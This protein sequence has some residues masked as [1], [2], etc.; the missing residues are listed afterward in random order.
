MDTE[1][2]PNY[3]SLF[4][5]ASI[6]T[7]VFSRLLK[8]F[9]T[10]A[11]ICALPEAEFVKMG[12]EAA[13]IEDLKAGA[14]DKKVRQ[15][16]DQDLSWSTGKENAIISYESRFYPPLLKEIQ[17]SP[18]LLYVVGKKSKLTEPQ[19]AIVGSRKSSNYGRRNAYWMANELS[20]AG[21]GIC[22][23]MAKGI[24]SE[25]HKGALDESNSTIAVMGTGADKIYPASNRKLAEQIKSNGALISEFPLGTPPLTYNFPR[26]NRIISGMSLGTL[27]VE[28]TPKSGSLITARFALEQNRDV[29]AFPGPIGGQES[30][31]CHA[32][33]KDGAKLVEE[34]VDIL[35]EIG[36]NVLAPPTEQA[37]ES[38][39]SHAH[40]KEAQEN[41][42]TQQQLM[43]LM[44]DQGCIMQLLLE[45]SGLGLQQLNVHLLQLEMQGRIVAEAGRYFRTL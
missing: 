43:K 29:F 28:A 33:I 1:N 4:H 17:C 10:V 37:L 5:C 35:E 38:D 45:S 27:V 7:P 18:P 24:D 15:L 36:I 12:F 32:L 44:G 19:F 8:E 21:L 26:R 3:L 39:S 13:Q 2:L 42:A 40:N 23:G 14:K 16:V 30:R 9:G 31:G 22:S 20:R 41:N 25:A 11:R 6:S 34:P